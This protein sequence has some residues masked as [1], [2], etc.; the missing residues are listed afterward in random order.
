TGEVMGMDRN[1]ARAYAKAQLGAGVRLPSQGTCFISVKDKDKSAVILMAW[2]LINLGFD[3]IATAGTASALQEAGVP[4]RRVN[5]VHE[6]QPHIGD[7]II[8]GDVQMIINTTASGP[9]MLKDKFSIRRVALARG[10]AQYTTIPG[11]RAAIEAIAAMQSGSLEVQSLQRYLK[12][13]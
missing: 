6:G 9:A 3:I 10:V 7:A 5:K 11:A 4:V 13:S 8:N 2:Q 12:A 1:F